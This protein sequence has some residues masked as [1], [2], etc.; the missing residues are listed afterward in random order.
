MKIV[1]LVIEAHVASIT[2]DRP[3]SEIITDSFKRNY[4]IDVNLPDRDSQKI[5][6]MYLKTD[7]DTRHNTTMETDEHSDEESLPDP[8]PTP[9]PSPTKPK[10]QTDF[11]VIPKRKHSPDTETKQ[12]KTKPNLKDK[13]DSYKVRILRSDKDDD[14]VPETIDHD[15]FYTQINE[16]KHGIKVQVYGNLD[17]FKH[18]FKH[19]LLIYRRDAIMTVRDDYFQ[20]FDRVAHMSHTHRD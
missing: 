16:R 15:W 11:T 13:Q 8:A 17:L 1:L 12:T 9:A 19:R 7:S 6:D 4:D 20:S 18:H 5:L 14:P 3:Y 2:G 10:K